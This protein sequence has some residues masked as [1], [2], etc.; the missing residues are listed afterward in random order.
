[1]ETKIKTQPLSAVKDTDI[2]KISPFLW[3]DT[4]AM[5]AGN[6]YASVFKNA[7]VKTSNRYSDEGAN[8]AGMQQGSIMAVVFKLEGQVEKCLIRDHPVGVPP[9]PPRRGVCYCLK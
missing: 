9:Y 7:R 5:D 1:L 3:F 2:Q 4:Q 8:A 6:F